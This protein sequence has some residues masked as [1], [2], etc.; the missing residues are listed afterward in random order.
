M[1]DIPDVSSLPPIVQTIATILAGGVVAFF[2]AMRYMRPHVVPS[3]DDLI[4]K[5]AS[6]TDMR[7][8]RDIA[9]SVRRMA[10]SAEEIRD[11][12]QRNENQDEI[13][14]KAQIL[15]DQIVK[16]RAIEDAGR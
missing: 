11:I 9:D 1:A 6:I 16:R 4:I 3:D 7:P 12:M 10:E 15:A 2:G 13:E 14:R 8:V 5:A